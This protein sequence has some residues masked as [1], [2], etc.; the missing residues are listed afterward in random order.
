MSNILAFIN[1]I[2]NVF[3]GEVYYSSIAL[4]IVVVPWLHPPYWYHFIISTVTSSSCRVLE[5]SF[6]RF[7]LNTILRVYVYSM[8]WHN[9]LIGYCPTDIHIL[10][11]N[12]IIQPGTKGS[13]LTPVSSGSSESSINSLETAFRLGGITNSIQL[14]RITLL[15]N[16]Q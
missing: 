14:S 10:R 16:F 7:D 5:T 6:L 13:L 8:L 15:A 3:E 11:V 9:D 2:S 4:P 1:S 12:N